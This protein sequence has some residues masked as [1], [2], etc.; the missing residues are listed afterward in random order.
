LELERYTWDGSSTEVSEE[1]TAFM[2]RCD[3]LIPSQT[4]FPIIDV[5]LGCLATLSQSEREGAARERRKLVGWGTAKKCPCFALL[6]EQTYGHR[7]H[8]RWRSANA[9][10]VSCEIYIFNVISSEC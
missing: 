4:A 2:Q 6:P 10:D 9:V 1:L 8:G 7:P 5:D 3:L